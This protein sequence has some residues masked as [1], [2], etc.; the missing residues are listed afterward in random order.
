LSN[1]KHNDTDVLLWGT[2]YAA[3]FRYLGLEEINPEFWQRSGDIPVI[4]IGYA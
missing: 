4:S 2:G 1:G 3:D